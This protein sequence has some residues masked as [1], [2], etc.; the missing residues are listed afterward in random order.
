MEKLSISAI[1]RT[2]FRFSSLGSVS[3]RNPGSFLYVP[4][5]HLLKNSKSF[6]GNKQLAAFFREHGI[7]QCWIRSGVRLVVQSIE[8]E[9]VCRI[10]SCRRRVLCNRLGGVC[11]AHLSLNQPT[12]RV[13]RN[14][15]HCDFDFPVGISSRLKRR[16]GDRRRELVLLGFFTLLHSLSLADVVKCN[17]CTNNGWQVLHFDLVSDLFDLRLVNICVVIIEHLLRVLPNRESLGDSSIHV[18]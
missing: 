8:L 2:A 4:I 13:V 10:H 17:R 18:Q 15:R 9:E 7:A 6:L 11:R 3:C 16:L 5:N 1:A 12:D 14:Q